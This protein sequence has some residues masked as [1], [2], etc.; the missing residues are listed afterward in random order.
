MEAEQWRGFF[1]E[2][3]RR[4]VYKVAVAYSVPGALSIG[5]ARNFGRR[6]LPCSLCTRSPKA[7]PAAVE[8]FR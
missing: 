4:N 6:W 2:L 5:L 8:A 3:K 1:A 7:A